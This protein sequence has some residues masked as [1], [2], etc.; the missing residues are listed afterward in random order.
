MISS[1]QIVEKALLPVQD[2]GLE[3][4]DRNFYMKEYPKCF[5]GSEFVTWLQNKG[6]ASDT[7]GATKIGQ[8]MVD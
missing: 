3:I 2:G 4:K 6:Y 7:N 5:I 8:D 1:E